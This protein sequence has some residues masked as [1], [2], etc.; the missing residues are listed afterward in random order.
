MDTGLYVG[1]SSQM[2][3]E[4]RLSTVAHNIANANTVG[5]RPSQI[6]FE[7]VLDGVATRSPSFVSEGQS[8]ANTAKG[9]LEQTGNSLDFAVKG[10]FWFSVETPAGTVVTR[11]GRFKMTNEGALVSLDGHPVLDPG[12][13]PIQLNP[14]GGTPQVS[15]DGFLMQNGQQIGAIGIFEYDPQA[16]FKRYGNSGIVTHQPPVAVVDDPQAGVVQGYVEKSGV[17]AVD[18]MSKLIMIHRNFENITSLLRDSESSLEAAIKTL[19]GSS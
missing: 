4:R 5:F 15:N 11:D 2:A 7:E 8:F 14:A 10:G 13:A 16:N 6:R 19:G 9:A 3:L 12:G 18:E 1:L 17:N